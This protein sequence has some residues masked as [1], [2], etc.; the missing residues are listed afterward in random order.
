M[1][2]PLGAKEGRMLYRI[3]SREQQWH[4]LIE[5][6]D[7]A[8]LQCDDRDYLVQ[9]ACKVAAERGFAVHVFDE[10]DQLEAKLE[11]RDGALAADRSYPVDYDLTSFSRFA[12]HI[13]ASD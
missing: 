3:V 8:I 11:F 6:Q 5:G 13:T 7:C 4:L 9:V 1:A 12:R 2:R 10:C